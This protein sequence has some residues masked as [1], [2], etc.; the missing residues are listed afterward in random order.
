MSEEQNYDLRI[1]Q[2]RASSIHPNYLSFT[3]NYAGGIWRISSC[4]C[5]DAQE[6]HH[7]EKVQSVLLLCELSGNGFVCCCEWKLLLW[8]PLS[9]V[10]M[11]ILH[12]WH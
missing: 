10:D 1:I 8:S 12:V 2:P 6:N 11:G 3:S 5:K 4:F 9:F 7:K